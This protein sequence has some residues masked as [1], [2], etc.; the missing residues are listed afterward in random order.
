M[1]TAEVTEDLSALF[2]LVPST[3]L[4][5]KLWAV[6]K[7]CAALL[8]E[9]KIPYV[10]MGTAA[11]AAHGIKPKDVPDIDFLVG[12]RPLVKDT[13][14]AD[15]SIAAE[16]GSKGGKGAAYYFKLDGHH[17]DPFT[18][19]KVDFVPAD[20]PIETGFL[21]MHGVELDGVRVMS[22]DT[23][24]GIKRWKGRPKDVEFL[25]LLEETQAEQAWVADGDDRRKGDRTGSKDT[26]AASSAAVGIGYACDPLL[27]PASLLILTPTY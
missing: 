17:E 1:A 23:A 19:I 5:P 24:L 18:S 11:L 25:K 12:E 26:Q 14:A 4:D 22:V 3:K 21:Q 20:N 13:D 10:L 16:G 6:V 15:G 8:Q 27:N 2:K 9:Q 7:R